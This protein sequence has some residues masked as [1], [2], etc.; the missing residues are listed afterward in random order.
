M[1]RY[2]FRCLMLAM[3]ALAIAAI[4]SAAVRPV[5]LFMCLVAASLAL[6]MYSQ[7]RGE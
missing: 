2:Q 3:V 5:A 1:T 7:S 4:A 6:W